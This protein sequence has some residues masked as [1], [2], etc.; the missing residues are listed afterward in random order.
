MSPIIAISKLS[1]RITSKAIKRKKWILAAKKLVEKLQWRAV[2]NEVVLCAWKSIP[3]ITEL[4][5]RHDKHLHEKGWKIDCN[6]KILQ[7]TLI[8]LSTAVLSGFSSGSWNWFH[9]QNSDASVTYLKTLKHD[10]VS[11]RESHDEHGINNPKP[12][13]ILC[14]H[15][16]DHD[17]HWTYEFESS[18]EEEEV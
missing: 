2:T 8:M 10:I 12:H 9:A 16:V 14:K 17:D 13:Q 1:K 4:S 18:T 6:K 15:S 5:Q 7:F 11:L 3:N